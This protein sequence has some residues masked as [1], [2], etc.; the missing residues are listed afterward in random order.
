MRSDDGVAGYSAC[1]KMLRLA[2]CLLLAFLVAGCA[3][4]QKVERGPKGFSEQQVQG[5][6]SFKL[7]QVVAQMEA[8]KI[9]DLVVIP[10]EQ[11]GGTRSS[12]DPVD[13]VSAASA[14]GA[15]AESI[16]VGLYYTPE[17][18]AVAYKDISSRLKNIQRDKRELFQ[19]KLACNSI[20]TYDP[21]NDLR[22]LQLEKQAKDLAKA[23]KSACD[24]PKAHPLGQAGKS[25]TSD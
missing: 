3:G 16:T 18:A 20:M 25:A 4:E 22:D 10:R 9:A 24:D 23:L 7:E 15:G 1:M 12:D 11:Q 21:G 13:V 19:L 8:Q 5:G 6:T 2:S 17:D 14:P